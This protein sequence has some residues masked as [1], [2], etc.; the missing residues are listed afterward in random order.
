MLYRGVYPETFDVIH[1][2]PG[3]VHRKAF[4]VL[5]AEGILSPGDLVLFTS[6][7]LEGIAGRTNTMQIVEVPA[8]DTA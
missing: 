2:E 5:I 7:D 8:D 1:T 6:G 4:D 3:V